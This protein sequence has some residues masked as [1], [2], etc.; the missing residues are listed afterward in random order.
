M[1]TT[2]RPTSDH[3]RELHLTFTFDRNELRLEYSLIGVFVHLAHC[4]TVGEPG[5]PALPQCLV[6]V[7]LPPHTRLIEIQA[8]AREILQISPEVIPVAPLQPL[9]PGIKAPYRGDQERP[10]YRRSEEEESWRARQQ[11]YSQRTEKPS[12]DPFPTPPFVPAN[13][14]L[15]AEATRRPA[16]RLLETADEG[17]TPVTTLNL[18]PVRLTA[19]GLVEFSSAIDVT[20]RYRPTKDADQLSGP[21]TNISSR[22]QAMRQIALTRLTVVN[23]ADV[24]DFSDLYPLFN[25]GA[26][27]LII[28]DNQRWDAAS[29]SPVGAV[30]GDLV[31]SFGRL[32]AWKRQRA[33][34]ARV[35]T[36]SDIVA[37]RY[38][39]FR[40]GS[41]DLQEVI[42]RFLQMAQANWGVAW[43]LLGGD[44]EIVPIR[45]VA[46]DVLGGVGRQA[47]DPPPENTAFW[48][49]NHL[50][51]HAVN[52]GDWWSAST[53]NLLV[54]SDNGLLIRYDA[55]GTSSPSAR[56]WFFTTDESYSTR[57]MI[58]TEFVRVNGPASEINAELQFL[59]HWNLIPTDLYYSSLVGPQYNLT[60]RHDWD[61]NANKV[62]GQ[63]GAGNFDGINF[64]PTVSLGRASVGTAAEADAF[65]NKVIAYEKFERPDGTPLEQDWTRRIVLVSENWGGRLAIGASPSHPPGDNSYHHAAGQTHSLIKLQATPDWNW[66]LLAWLSEGDVRL[67]P[68][69]TDAATAGRGWFFARD[70]SDL[71]PHI[72]TIPLPGGELIRLPLPS[73]WIAVYGTAEELAPPL[74]LLNNT[75][76]DSSLA[77]QEELGELLRATTSTFT[78]IKRLY[79]DI[80]DMTPAQVASGPLELLTRDGLRN[81]L[82]AGPHIVSLSGHGNSAGCCRLNPAMADALTNGYHTFIA[83]ADSCLTNQLDT[84]CVSEHLIANPNGGAVAYL[85][86]T[87]FSWIGVGDD[88]QRRFFGEW[89]R[90]GGNA[91]LGLLNDSRAGLYSSDDP[92]NRWV[93]L[94]LHLVGDP[95]MPARWRD[96]VKFRVPEVYLF[97]KL[98]LILEDPNP[99]DPV[100]EQPYLKNWGQTYIHLRQGTRERLVTTARGGEPEVPLAG[101]RS[102]LATVTVTR[103]GHRPVVQ[104]IDLKRPQSALRG[105]KLGKAILLFLGGLILFKALQSASDD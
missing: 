45:H 61:L 79:E 31:A 84:D 91:H 43:V 98:R 11:T 50:R 75:V 2:I 56:G 64:T 41:R 28:T 52:L 3:E 74:Y 51:I 57:S 93:M 39:D 20:L 55:T 90:L 76:L 21:V 101:F 85:G 97:D 65:I 10:V 38:G 36:I 16:A 24:F 29:I 34:K 80:E 1:K 71:T 42:R 81:A 103:A 100:I 96:P 37:N 33:L 99:P 30:S 35:V 44:T 104:R 87:R 25:L 86:N 32:A 68:Y 47:V 69:R 105:V 88:Y 54:R 59:Y 40:G 12:I 49:G 83:Y 82:N 63:H 95:E 17:L 70:S 48:A 58:E 15:Y 7:A 78:E 9:R 6:R 66:S 53:D 27:Y 18:N 94:S 92:Y 22:A 8:E 13:A 77:D 46:S 19:G 102:G 72:M 14:A 89:A 73:Q 67:L 23:R 4:P 62:Y 26:D 5:S 60:G